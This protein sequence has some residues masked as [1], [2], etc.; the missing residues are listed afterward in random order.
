MTAPPLP[1]QSTSWDEWRIAGLDN[2]GSIDATF[3]VTEQETALGQRESFT[4]CEPP[5]DRVV[6][7]HRTVT[8]TEPT[9]VEDLTNA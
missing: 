7:Q 9:E 3:W 8:A 1:G 6:L 4:A 2:D 5:F